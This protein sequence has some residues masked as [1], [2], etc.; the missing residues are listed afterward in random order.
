MLQIL[1]PGHDKPNPPGCRFL[2]IADLMISSIRTNIFLPGPVYP[3]P[4]DYSY[5]DLAVTA[6]VINDSSSNYYYLRVI[7]SG[8]CGGRSDFFVCR[9]DPSLE[10]VMVMLMVGPSLR[11]IRSTAAAVGLVMRMMMMVHGGVG[12]RSVNTAVAT[13]ATV[14]AV[15]ARRRGVVSSGGWPCS[16]GSSWVGRGEKRQLI[17]WSKICTSETGSPRDANGRGSASGQGQ[18]Q[19]R[20]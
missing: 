16:V 19:E 1:W 8:P 15:V 12:R 9:L 2:I 10:R 14:A 4:F 7:V 11:R 6:V 18:Q 13:A 17:K 3:L 5:T 20:G